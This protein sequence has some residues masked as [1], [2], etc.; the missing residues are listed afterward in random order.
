MRVRGLLVL[1]V[2][3]LVV[4]AILGTGASS[5]AEDCGIGTA[6]TVPCANVKVVTPPGRKQPVGSTFSFTASASVGGNGDPI[7]EYEWDWDGDNT[8]DN[9]TG[10]TPTAAHTYSAAGVYTVKMKVT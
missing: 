1:S 6:G 9:S 10:T 3:A 7:R 4:P 5:A 2:I 8:F